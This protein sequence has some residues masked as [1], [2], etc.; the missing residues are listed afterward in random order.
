[1]GVLL[2]VM[3]LLIF[4]SAVFVLFALSGDFQKGVKPDTE[5]MPEKYRKKHS[6]IVD[7]FEEDRREIEILKDTV[8]VAIEKLEYL[9]RMGII[10]AKEH[11]L[12][13][14]LF[15]NYRRDYGT[16]FHYSLHRRRG[17]RRD[18]DDLID[19]EVYPWMYRAG[20]RYQ[21]EIEDVNRLTS[22]MMI[23]IDILYGQ[24]E[25]KEEL[26]QMSRKHDVPFEVFYN[27]MTYKI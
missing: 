15:L 6:G 18:P 5:C 3:V 22:K 11:T 4:V 17:W 1:M 8:S 25:G 13:D 24:I 16:D 14:I 19:S 9:H 27:G 20:I 2:S 7:M 21:R 26:L 12:L 23:Y 10:G